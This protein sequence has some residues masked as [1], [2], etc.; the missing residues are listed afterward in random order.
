MDDERATA[1]IPG[2]ARRTAVITGGGLGATVV[3]A[4]VGAGLGVAVYALSGA[5]PKAPN[6]EGFLA[7]PDPA[8]PSPPLFAKLRPTEIVENPP[9][10][11]P[12]S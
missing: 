1:Q 7:G 6:I 3:P 12:V 10:L 4:I 9:V 8:W 5:R 11:E 2:P